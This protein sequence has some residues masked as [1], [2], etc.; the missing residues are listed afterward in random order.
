MLKKGEEETW[1][2]KEEESQR[3]K[4]ENKE[5]KAEKE[6]SKVPEFLQATRVPQTL[7]ATLQ[8]SLQYLL[9]NE[10][11]SNFMLNGRKKKLECQDWMAF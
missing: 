7:D 9:T 6:E 10:I 4:E 8:N 5:G 3:K 2:K 1:R 11:V